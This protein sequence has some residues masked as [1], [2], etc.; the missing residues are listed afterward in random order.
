V[1]EISKYPEKSGKLFLSILSTSRTIEI[2]YIQVRIL[3]E[4]RDSSEIGYSNDRVY[5]VL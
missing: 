2:L 3:G 4:G 5:R 1:Y